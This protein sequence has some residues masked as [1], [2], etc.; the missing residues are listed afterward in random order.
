MTAEPLATEAAP[1]ASWLRP[2]HIHTARDEDGKPLATVTCP[3]CLST[4]IVTEYHWGLAAGFHCWDA[5]HTLQMA[6]GMTEEEYSAALKAEHLCRACLACQY[7][8][9]ERTADA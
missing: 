5:V 8:W 6:T 4:D 1:S 9:C 3:K 7:C 2:F